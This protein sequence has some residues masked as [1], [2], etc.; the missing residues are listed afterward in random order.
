MTTILTQG[1]NLD[2]LKYDFEIKIEMQIFNV[3]S[4]ADGQILGSG[5]NIPFLTE[6]QRHDVCIATFKT[7]N[8]LKVLL[9]RPTCDQID[10]KNHA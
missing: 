6:Q 2:F 8:F 1:A 3:G 5:S 10:T 9:E 7:V 4:R